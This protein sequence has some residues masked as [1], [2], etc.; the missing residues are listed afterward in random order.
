MSS[1]LPKIIITLPIHNEEAILVH[2]T[3]LLHAYCTHILRDVSWDILI[4]NNGS[5]DRSEELCISLASR[6]PH[7]I[8]EKRDASGR[9]GALKQAWLSHEADVYLYMD[10]DLA[11]DI[12]HLPL[13]ISTILSGDYDIATGSRLISGAHTKRSLFRTACSIIYNHLPILFFPSFPVRDAQC[14]FKAISRR[15]RGSLLPAVQ[16]SG[17]F[18]DTELLIRAH[19]E[20][21][22][23]GEFPILW[24]DQRFIK[25]KSKVRI[26]ETGLMNIRKLFHLKRTL[27]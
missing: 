9:G 8:I 25:R 11:T 12:Q 27:R 24:R 13:L 10:S 18:F 19:R 15:V 1:S 22:R 7:L 3:E 20:G 21:Y 14:G 2:H 4:A 23:I 26:L 6:L 17:W 16:D 5:S